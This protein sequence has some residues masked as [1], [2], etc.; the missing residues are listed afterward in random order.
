MYFNQIINA[1]VKVYMIFHLSKQKWSNRGN[2]SAGGGT[3]LIDRV[4]NAVALSQ[5]ITTVV[6]F[7]T[8]LALYIGVLHL[9]ASLF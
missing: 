8:G 7:V 5:M 1:S 2:Q 3:A 6:A 9:P 4:K